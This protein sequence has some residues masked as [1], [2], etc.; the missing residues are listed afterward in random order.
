MRILFKNYIADEYNLYKISRSTEDYFICSGEGYLDSN[1][2][3]KYLYNNVTSTDNYLYEYDTKSI[4]EYFY[5]YNISLLQKDNDFL[6]GES[7]TDEMEKNIYWYII[8]SI[9]KE[10]SCNKYSPI[11]SK[12]ITVLDTQY[13]ALEQPQPM[14]AELAKA[15]TFEKAINFTKKYGSL[16]NPYLYTESYKLYNKNEGLPCHLGL[17]KD[18]MNVFFETCKYYNNIFNNYFIDTNDS[19]IF[20]YI[21]CDYFYFYQREIELLSEIKYELQEIKKIKNV[22]SKPI[23]RLVVL[24]SNIMVNFNNDILS[25]EGVRDDFEDTDMFL[26][27]PQLD[28]RYKIIS[29]NVVK[30]KRIND[31]KNDFDFDAELAKYL[32]KYKKQVENA[33]NESFTLMIFSLYDLIKY[34]QSKEDI[35]IKNNVKLQ[36]FYKLKN[37]LLYIVKDR[38]INLLS[39]TAEQSVNFYLK[40]VNITSINEN[41]TY[42]FLSPITAI[43]FLFYFDYSGEKEFKRCANERCQAIFACPVS[44]ERKKFCCKLCGDRTAKRRSKERNKN[45]KNEA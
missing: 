7:E 35:D 8:K 5:G 23:E 20:D 14:Y 34:C 10:N 26:D 29:S 6:I 45:K 31:N 15:N 41:N 21:D 19:Y 27:Y 37:S 12:E 2:I 39:D 4:K 33:N 22:K 32:E 11:P 13:P 18:N 3:D 40:N 1:T 30:T 44:N 9:K 38:L 43:F 36:Q 17:D 25:L 24:Y 16:L 28:L 42:R